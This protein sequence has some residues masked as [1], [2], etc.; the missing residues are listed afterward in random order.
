MQHSRAKEKAVKSEN[1][2]KDSSKTGKSDD[3]HKKMLLKVLHGFTVLQRNQCEFLI[4]KFNK[5][6]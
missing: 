4:R 2:D 5:I 3:H 1:G 6:K